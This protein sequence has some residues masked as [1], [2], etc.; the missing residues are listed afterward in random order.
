MTAED[1]GYLN[2][3]IALEERAIRKGH[4]TKWRETSCFPLADKD[5]RKK[6]LGSIIVTLPN[7]KYPEGK[8]E[9]RFN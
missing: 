7:D 6:W 8:V 4:R 3:A 1:R 9:R 2:F 5:G